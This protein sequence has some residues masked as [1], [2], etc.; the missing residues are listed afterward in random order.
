MVSPNWY[1]LLLGNSTSA[2]EATKDLMGEFLGVL[3]ESEYRPSLMAMFA[4]T[5]EHDEEGGEGQVQLYFSPA[6]AEF[7]EAIGAAPC[8]RPSTVGLRLLIGDQPCWP[9]LFPGE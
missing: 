5:T 3:S 2:Y 1:G 8:D 6:A 7:A 4:S 9:R